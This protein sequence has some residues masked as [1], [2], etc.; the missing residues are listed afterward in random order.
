M[1]KLLKSKTFW[2]G[3]TAIV[4]A[5]TGYAAGEMTGAMAIQTA[6]TAL[7]AIFLRDGYNKR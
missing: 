2:T 6:F 7:L 5:G 1:K 4:T 3:V